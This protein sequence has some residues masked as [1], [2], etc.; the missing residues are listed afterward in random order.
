MSSLSWACT[1]TF[2][3]NPVLM[4][5]NVCERQDSRAHASNLV[6]VLA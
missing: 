3:L 5:G 2:F 4:N 6:G 1:L